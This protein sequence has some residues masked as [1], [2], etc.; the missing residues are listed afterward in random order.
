M[1]DEELDLVG[2]SN[3]QLLTC[4][5]IAIDEAKWSRLTLKSKDVSRLAQP[6]VYYT[7]RLRFLDREIEYLEAMQ[8]R[9]KSRLERGSRVTG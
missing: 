8:Q 9:V 7:E 2:G 4:L 3:K 1:A 6:E 5:N